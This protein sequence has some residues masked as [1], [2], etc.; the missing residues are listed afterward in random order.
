MTGKTISIP[1]VTNPEI[2]VQL[3]EIYKSFNNQDKLENEL[4]CYQCHNYKYY[5]EMI[6]QVYGNRNRYSCLDCITE[7][8]I[9]K[10][11][12]K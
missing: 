10:N 4:L 7:K 2:R 11:K 8:I 1:P 6:K 12:K 9:E 5:T 3:N